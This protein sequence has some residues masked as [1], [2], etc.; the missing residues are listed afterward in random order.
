[1]QYAAVE[2]VRDSR[3]CSL[4]VSGD[5]AKAEAITRLS[6]SGSSPAD[7]Q[8]LVDALQHCSDAEPAPVRIDERQ[9]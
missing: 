3:Y 2:V 8:R 7:L 4:S 5:D 1:M 9:A 6:A